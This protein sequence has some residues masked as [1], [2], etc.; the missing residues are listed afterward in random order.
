[1]IRYLQNISLL[2]YNTFGVDVRAS[3]L[4]HL[5]SRGQLTEL[6]EFPGFTEM[7]GDMGHLLVLGQGSN[8]L[9]TGDF[10]GVVVRNEI[11]GI[12]VIDE[13]ESS[14]VVEAGS[15]VIWNDLVDFAVSRGWWGIENLALIPGTVGAAPVQNI[16]AYGAEA[17]DVIMRVNAFHLQSREWLVLE[18]SECG[19]GY[20]DSIFKRE[21]RNKTIICSVAFRLS[22]KARPMLDYSGIREELERMNISEPSARDISSAVASVRRSKLPDPAVLGNAGSFFKNPVVSETEYR[23]LL[24]AF[25]GLRAHR[26]G[27]NYK[28]PAA[29]LIEQ[30]GWKGCRVGNTGS[31]EKQPLII[32]NLGNASGKEILEFSEKICESVY[33]RSGI[34]LEREVNV[35]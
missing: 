12:R 22:K 30:A 6:I 20:R 9:F 24:A 4:F 14:V 17:A 25:P 15:G 23:R 27:D 32:V 16:G 29:W 11:T 31:Y 13:D 35:L 18:N 1:M 34:S 21:L 33:S 19:F 26:Q 28:I 8:I 2:P 7:A 3:H 5:E 10:P